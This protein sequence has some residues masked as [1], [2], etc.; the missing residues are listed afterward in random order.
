MDAFQHLFLEQSMNR[1]GGGRGGEKCV[2]GPCI[3]SC[4]PRFSSEDAPHSI[5]STPEGLPGSGFPAR[6]EE[7]P[8]LQGRLGAAPVG[9]WSP[10]S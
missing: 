1:W 9:S 3:P 2:G 7:T 5:D 8:S 4:T 6:G 10:V